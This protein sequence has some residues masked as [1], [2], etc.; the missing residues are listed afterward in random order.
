MKDLEISVYGGKFEDSINIIRS[1]GSIKSIY[2]KDSTSDALDI[3]FSN[4]YIEDIK[5]INSGNDC[6]DLS[7]EII[8]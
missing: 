7:S 1:Q 6:V 5:I 4:L 3:D 8:I 2:L